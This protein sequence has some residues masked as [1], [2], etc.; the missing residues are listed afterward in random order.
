MN[1]SYSSSFFFIKMFTN[2]STNSWVK[3]WFVDI[4]VLT[5]RG[6]FRRKGL[7]FPLGSDQPFQCLVLFN[8]RFL[9]L[10][11]YT[12]FSQIQDL[13]AANSGKYFRT[14]ILLILFDWILNY[15]NI[16]SPKGEVFR[17][18]RY[19]TFQNGR[20]QSIDEVDNEDVLEI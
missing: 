15:L 2:S 3:I 13:N 1:Y 6:N 8:S 12:N 7:E 17:I 10:L 4:S 5:K 18:S 16:R 20:I 11:I 19:G 14:K 9:R